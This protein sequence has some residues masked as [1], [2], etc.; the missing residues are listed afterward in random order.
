MG[1]GRDIIRKPATPTMPIVPFP[2]PASAKSLAVRI[3]KD[4]SFK[5]ELQ[6]I[7]SNFWIDVLKLTMKRFNVSAKV[8]VYGLLPILSELQGEYMSK[9]VEGAIK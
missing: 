7:I 8:A 9:A 5:S 1:E 6:E 2:I 3:S 4:E